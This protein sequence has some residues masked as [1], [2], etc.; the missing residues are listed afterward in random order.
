M[1][2]RASNTNL[3]NSQLRGH[4]MTDILFGLGVTQYHDS[5]RNCLSLAEV[6]GTVSAQVP[7]ITICTSVWPSAVAARSAGWPRVDLL[8]LLLLC[9]LGP[10]TGICW[11]CSSFS[12][13]TTRMSSSTMAL[14]ASEAAVLDAVWLFRCRGAALPAPTSG[15]LNCLHDSK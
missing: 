4:C 14:P 15:F 12:S 8:S 11:Q 7:S 6:I 3:S 2:V 13:F 5:P 9:L 10:A 1:Q